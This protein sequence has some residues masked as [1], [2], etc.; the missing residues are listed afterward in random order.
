MATPPITAREL[1][2]IL[3]VTGSSKNNHPAKT[4]STG[5]DNCNVAA[6]IAAKC[7]RMLYH[8]AYPNAEAMAPE[9]TA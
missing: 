8:K 7:T 1:K 4:A 9:A 2:M 6:L 5:T 3:S